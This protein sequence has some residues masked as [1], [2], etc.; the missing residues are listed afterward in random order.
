MAIELYNKPTIKYRVEGFGLFI[1][2]AWE[3]ILKAHMINKF[4][5]DSIYY[6]NHPER[7]LSLE[8]CVQKIFTNN[9]ATSFVKL[10]KNSNS[11]VN[12]IKELKDPNNTH[13]YTAKACIK[14]INERLLKDKVTILYNGNITRFNSFHFTNFCKHYN[15]KNNEKFCYIHKQFTHPQYSYSQQIIDFIVSEI[16]KDSENILDNIKK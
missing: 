16:E 15:L 10:D 7:T 2:N 8:N 6:K 14:A 3:L 1:C 5:E 4:G 9:K 11:T 12:I 13:N